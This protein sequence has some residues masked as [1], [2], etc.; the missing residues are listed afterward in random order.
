MTT[1]LDK[2]DKII[3]DAKNILIVQADNPDGDS[4]GSALAL[5]QILSDMGKIPH[6]YCGVTIPHYL[7][8]LKGWDR[9]YTDIPNLIDATIIVDTS[10]NILLEQLNKNSGL[11]RVL[12]KPVIVL[13]HHSNVKCDIPYATDIYNDPSYIAT[14]ELIYEIAKELKW[15]LKVEAMEPLMQSIL[16]DSLGLSS[17]S[18]PSDAYRRVA[19]MIDAGVNRGTLEESR[20][21]LSKMPISVFRYKGKLI[22]RSEFYDNDRIAYAQIPEEELYD[23]GTLYNPA[24]LISNELLMVESVEIAVVIKTYKGK[25][26]GSIRCSGSQGIA[27]KLAEKY[28]GGGH[29]YA[30]GF[31]IE[32]KNIDVQKIKNELL[33]EIPKLLNE[34]DSQ[35]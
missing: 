33:T 27:N 32:S 14:G 11:S 1:K 34:R 21:Q 25:I 16:S 12:T 10:A 18:T 20:K 2:L 5:E 13:D 31:K 35:S 29:P 7:R 15:P 4:L 6:L 28:G 26:T 22:E 9:V 23:V 30:A 3:K 8:F 24:P 19:D 17:A